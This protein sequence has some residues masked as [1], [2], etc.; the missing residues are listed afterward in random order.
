MGC[1]SLERFANFFI[2]AVLLLA[3]TYMY[4]RPGMM[5]K[6]ATKSLASK[7]ITEERVEE[8]LKT[9][10]EAKRI[11]KNK[12]YWN[13]C[14]QGYELINSS[15]VSPELKEQVKQTMENMGVSGI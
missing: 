11:P 4:S 8:Y 7:E 10:K 1:D 6:K 15:Q 13:S 14:K 2:L 3:I 12:E 9:L 5:V